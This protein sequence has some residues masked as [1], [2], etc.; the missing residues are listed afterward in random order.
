MFLVAVHSPGH[1]NKPAQAEPWGWIP[2]KSRLNHSKCLHWPAGWV[3]RS[4]IPMFLI[5]KNVQAYCVT[6]LHWLN[7]H[8]FPLSH[9]LATVWLQ[10][11][12]DHSPESVHVF[13]ELLP[14]F[15]GWTSQNKFGSDRWLLLLRTG[16]EKKHQV[17]IN[18]IC[19][20]RKNKNNTISKALVDML[21]LT[22][23]YFLRIKVASL[24]VCACWSGK[25]QS[26]GARSVGWNLRSSNY[27]NGNMKL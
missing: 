13:T 21:H 6:N 23:I 1:V 27:G 11:H 18:I 4:P 5:R 22:P 2:F 26:R 15:G 8:L 25:I 14:I 3:K 7:K 16:R 20:F 24:C 19:P 17:K 10:R 9:M 12:L